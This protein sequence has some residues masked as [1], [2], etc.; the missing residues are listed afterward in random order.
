MRFNYHDLR[1]CIIYIMITSTSKRQKSKSESK[2]KT[3]PNVDN[4]SSIPKPMVVEKKP[5]I[6]IVL[7]GAGL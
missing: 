7:E 4:K 6:T 2:Q 3:K 1:D 5:V